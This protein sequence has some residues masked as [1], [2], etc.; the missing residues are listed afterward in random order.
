MSVPTRER[1]LIDGVWRYVTVDQ[2]GGGGG[3]QTLEAVL[4]TGNDANGLDVLGVFSLKAQFIDPVAGFGGQLPINT[5]G[6]TLD[7]G[8]GGITNAGT[9]DTAGGDVSFGNG[10][11]TGLSDPS[12]PQDADT[13]AARDAAIAAALPAAFTQGRYGG[14][15]TA[16]ANGANADFPWTLDSGT[17]LLDLSTPAAPS[18]V[19]AGTYA[20]SFSLS[21][22]SA[23]TAGG[24]ANFQ[25]AAGSAGIVYGR[26]FTSASGSIVTALDATNIVILT[27]SNED[28][29][30]ARDFSMDV[31]IV[32]LA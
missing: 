8:S 20:I 4:T 5:G 2:N 1:R 16:V 12:A 21:A 31:V 24:F 28:G 9:I 26:L 3:S 13:Q 15:L 30:A 14:T 11:A 32:K 6:G 19:E 18:T 23:F 27:V 29:V 10:R 7:L 22:G 25:L 17:A